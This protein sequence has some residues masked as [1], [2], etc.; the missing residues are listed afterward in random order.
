MLDDT[1]IMWEE[2][3]LKKKILVV[4]ELH[5]DIFYKTDALT[6]I[7]QQISRQLFLK[8][9]SMQGSESEI[10]NIVS[11]AL[12][13]TTKKFSCDSKIVR[14]GNGNNSATILANL[15]IPTGLLT[16]IGEDSLW[17]IPELEKLGIDITTVFV[18]K[19]LT[20]TS[21]IVEDANYTKIFTSK[22]L[23]D[24]MNFEGI[25]F[26][27]DLFDDSMIVF[28]TPMDLKYKHILE[29]A[30]NAEKLVA[31]TIELQKFIQFSEVETLLSAKPEILFCNLNDAYEICKKDFETPFP[32]FEE[33]KKT[34]DEE[35]TKN[36]EYE[37]QLK[38]LINVDLFFGK[39]ANVRIYTSGN[40]GSWVRFGPL[41]L[42]YREPFA[43]DIK[44]RVGAGDTFAAGFLSKL[45]EKISSPLEYLGQTKEEN[46]WLFKVC[47]LYATGASGVRISSGKFP[48][49][50]EIREFLKEKME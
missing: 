35:K 27:I 21:A 24:E 45:N 1:V 4:G 13:R 17:M 25:E 34:L 23:K 3:S 16:V 28:I 44:T 12:H 8:K 7:V 40:M 2:M 30:V 33:F 42:I 9:S 29:V 26:P 39:L 5:R 6:N 20:P 14:G 46:E 49:N 15:G 36:A 50:D 22:N 41:K 19:V 37:Y 32:T 48:D 38:K 18:K 31:V 10:E 43:V 47:L 11:N